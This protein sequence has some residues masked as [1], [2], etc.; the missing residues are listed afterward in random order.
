MS[1]NNTLLAVALVGGFFLLNRR[2]AQSPVYVQQPVPSS[3]PASVG[4]G[5]QQMAQ[6]AV[7]G[8]LSAFAYG[9]ANNTSQTNFPSYSD[10]V[11]AIRG[12][13]AQESAGYFDGYGWVGSGQSYQTTW[14]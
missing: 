14:G 9:P 5:W 10:P 11:D 6:G 4:N 13:I 12:G 1:N 8:L 3:M 7:A 2:P